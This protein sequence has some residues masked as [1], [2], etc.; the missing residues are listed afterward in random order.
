MSNNELTTEVAGQISHWHSKAQEYATASK[1]HAIEALES[2][3][4]AGNY[5]HQA[6]QGL[7]NGQLLKWLRDNVNDL[8]PKQAKA[9]LS[10]Y[11]TSEKQKLEEKTLDHRQLLMLGIIEQK[12]AVA[13]PIE[14]KQVSDQK[15]MGYIHNL[16]G[17]WSKTTADRPVNS[18][19]YDEREAIKAQLH[20]LV[21]I[22]NSL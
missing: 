3:V 21:E 4:N 8:T 17:W 14:N 22:Y 12:E 13:T 6:E 9:Y 1:Q 18:W 20:P 2:A 19:N 5:I 10:L 11:H 7:S 15:W 16:R